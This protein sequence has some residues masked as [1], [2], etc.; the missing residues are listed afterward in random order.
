MAK[1]ATEDQRQR[2]REGRERRK[3]LT[4]EPFEKL[5]EKARED[6]ESPARGAALKQTVATAAA[7]ALAAGIAGAAK[8]LHDRRES[9]E[10]ADQEP[11]DDDRADDEGGQ[12]PAAAAQ[13]PDEDDAEGDT[14]DEPSDAEGEG[15]QE[16]AAEAE[17][18]AGHEDEKDEE[19]QARGASP[20]D[21]K[22]VVEEARKQLQEILGV[23]PESVSGFERSDE[24]WTVSLEVV[25][26]RRIP[27]STD[28]LSSYEVTLD[29]D[30]N[31]VGV[32]QTR[33]YR[34]S[35]VEEGS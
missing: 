22:A 20:G 12:E 11:D 14:A 25:E 21:A 34:R 27:E 33:R 26:M 8:A 28:V 2:R 1:P 16:P 6:D 18:Q 7:G 4:S 9:D 24:R 31:V 13:A 10:P 32:S 19:P 17:A 29:D 3:S 23:E 35:Q 5:D 30:R 15:D